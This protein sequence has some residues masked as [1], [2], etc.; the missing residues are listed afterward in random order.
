LNLNTLLLSTNWLRIDDL[1]STE[2]YSHIGSAW[3]I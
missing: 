1:D 2:S 3:G